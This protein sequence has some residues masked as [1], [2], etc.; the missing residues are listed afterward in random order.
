MIENLN[1]KISGLIEVREY[2]TFYGL[3]FDFPMKKKKKEEFNNLAT[4]TCVHFFFGIEMVERIIKSLFDIGSARR[5]RLIL[6][7]L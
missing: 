5:N 1:I 3:I 7:R 4:V 6:L 2:V